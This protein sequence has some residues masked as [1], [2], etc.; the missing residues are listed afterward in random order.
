MKRNKAA[1]GVHASQMDLKRSRTVLKERIWFRSHRT[2]L[3]HAVATENLPGKQARF[4]ESA[5]R[6]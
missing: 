1:F 5:S 4:M 2:I 6:K 3:L